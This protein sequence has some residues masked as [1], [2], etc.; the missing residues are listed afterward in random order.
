[1][2]G[3]VAV[4]SDLASALVI[5]LTLPDGRQVGLLNLSRERGQRTFLARDL[6]RASRVGSQIALVIGNAQLVSE[7]RQSRNE[8]EV[9]F[10]RLPYAIWLFDRAGNLR[11]CNATACAIGT[12]LP[13]SWGVTEGLGNWDVRDLDSGKWWRVTRLPAGEANL[14]TAEDIT[15]AKGRAREEARLRRLAEI[16]Q[17]TATLAHEI[18]N[19][20][21][22]IRTAAQMI[23]SCPEQQEEFAGI[24]QEEADK[25]NELCNDL[26]EFARP[27]SLKIEE[28][29]LTSLAKRVA[30]LE[31]MPLQSR[32]IAL[33]L[34]AAPPDLSIPVDP[35]RVEQ[36]IRNLVLN[37]ADACPEGGQI[38]VEVEAREL[39]VVDNGHGMDRPTQ[40]RLFTPFFTTKAKG[41]GLGLS[42]A[43]KV[44]EAHGGVIAVQSEVGQGTVVSVSFQEAA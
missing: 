40:E 35:M 27:M 3:K 22:G 15:E 24:I 6:D 34:A 17:L 29:S 7:A 20:L 43:R 8:L 13:T 41:T 42:Y 10:S 38:R 14:V 25:L 39:R 23:G 5:P 16:G 36:V 9:L 33:E 30:E 37:A 12:S 19:P 4:R 1:M 21:T 32:G 26:L 18:R 44:V 28:V 31:A 11:E 2:A